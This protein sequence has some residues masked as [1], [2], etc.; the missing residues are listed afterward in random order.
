MVEKN[1]NKFPFE[2]VLHFKKNKTNNRAKLSPKYLL[3]FFLKETF[4]YRAIKCG[5]FDLSQ[6]HDLREF[7]SSSCTKLEKLHLFSPQMS[8]W[9][10]DKLIIR[11]KWTSTYGFKLSNVS[12]WK[13][14]RMK[15]LKLN[16]ISNL[17]LY[18]Y[19]YIYIYIHNI[20]V[21]ILLSFLC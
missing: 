20:Y 10:Y 15:M 5:C 19:I 6:H 13:I 18:I 17:H 7:N 1:K 2:T 21:A 14:S 8:K 11:N 16:F 3:S 9:H 12:V 4:Y